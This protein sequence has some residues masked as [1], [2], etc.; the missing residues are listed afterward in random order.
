MKNAASDLVLKDLVLI[1]GGHSHIAVLKSFGMKP[2]PGLRL[3]LITRD[4]HTPYSGMLPGYIAGHYSYDDAHIDLRPLALFAGA[5]L[6]HAE[7]KGL[8]LSEKKVY[9]RNRPPVHYDVLSINTGSRPNVIGVP[10]AED[11]T[12]PVK[13]ID[14]F[15]LGW[16]DIV[17]R[18][19]ASKGKFRI[20]VVGGGAGGVELA[21]SSQYR[22]RGILQRE[23]GSA[24]QLEYY[25]VTNTPEILPTHNRLVR[26]KFRRVLDSRDIRVLTDHAVERVA[27]SL[28]ICEGDR[29][30]T[31]DAIIWVTQASAPTW[32][33]EAGL[34]TDNSGFLRV[35]SCLQSLSHPDVFA[36]GDIASVVG[37]P[38]P[39]SGVFAV[40]QGPPLTKNLRRHVY[41][42]RPKAFIPQHKF[43]G[44]ISTGDKYAVASRGRWSLEGEWVWRLK[45]WIDCRFMDKYSD[46]PEMSSEEKTKVAPGLANADALKEISTIAMRCGGCGAKVGSS[47]LSRV[48][49]RLAPVT[50]DDIIIGLQSPDDAAVMEVPSG[51]VMVQSVDYFRSFLEDPYL[52]GKIA[53]NHSLGDLF[54]MGAQPQSAM[55]IATVPFGRER[56][57]EDQ[58]Y[59]LMLGALE[60]LNAC[61]A[62]L[63]GG[64]SSEGAE[65][66][67]GLSVTGLIERSEVMRKGGMQAGDLLLLTKPLG[68]GTLFAADM[69][70]K[71]KG[72]WVQG[73]IQSMLVSNQGAA[74]CLHRYGATACTDVTGFGL[75]GHLVEMTRASDCDAA[76]DLNALP[77][78]DGALSTL[79]E[80]IFSSLQPQN[81]RLRRAIRDLDGLQNH[82]HFPLLFDPQTAGGL[83]AS[84]PP[85][86]AENCLQ[87]LHQQGYALST[88]IGHVASRGDALEPIRLYTNDDPLKYEG[89]ADDRVETDVQ[90]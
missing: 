1:G 7:V 63:V 36:A 87:E 49:D 72:R 65:L 53:A 30:I 68:T 33:N 6:Y 22:L 9:C 5:R 26:R 24:D 32:L 16:F 17:K 50:R 89:Y 15:L 88:I 62:S 23:C 43:L 86:H 19:L 59:Q 67:F 46:L 66:A 37:Y 71:A 14:R 40:R 70:R 4:I 69:R 58:L 61:G 52:F 90:A 35:N 57:V 27:P 45:N 12:L 81:V 54:A 3:T 39:K 74:E 73:A 29:H 82:A 75:L 34:E 48:V 80:G 11:H 25:L 47:V 44:L 79:R 31:A 85:E 41:G 8:E 55:A 76:L 64:H 20:A 84:V 83:L 60:A 28:L 51:A 42:K 18:V 38:R 13:P 77:V 2:I 10:G 56:E 21:L 78:L